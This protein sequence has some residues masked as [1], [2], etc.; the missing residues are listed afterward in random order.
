MS[1]KQCE[2]NNKDGGNCKA[3]AN[4]SG[5]C[6]MHDETKGKERA[7]AR[8]NGGLATKQ[9]HLADASRLPSEIR[10]IEDVFAVLDYT[11][12]ET[13]GLDNS[14]N[15]GRLLVSIAHGFIEALK[16]GELEKRL[17]SIEIALK[18]RKVK[19]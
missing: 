17:E 19:K 1:K 2:A 7:L 5:F 12:R 16:V 6:F 13:V 8:R 18:T 15:R 11:L 9:P 3:F 14:I 10:K 4:E